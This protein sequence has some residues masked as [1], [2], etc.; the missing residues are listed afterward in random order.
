MPSK[1]SKSDITIAMYQNTNRMVDKLSRMGYIIIAEVTPLIIYFSNA[2]Y[3][4]FIYFTTDVGGDTF[5]LPYVV[6]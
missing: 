5:D 6:W 4:Y 3:D 2:I 1:G